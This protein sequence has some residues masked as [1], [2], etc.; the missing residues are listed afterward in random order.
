MGDHHGCDAQLLLQ[1]LDFVAQMH[2]HF[3]VKRRERFIKQQ[4]T[5]AG[6]DGAR[7]RNALL[8]ATRQLCRILLGLFGQT[9][10][11]QQ[12]YHTIGNLWFAAAGV[13]QSEGNI[14][15]DCQ[16]RKQSI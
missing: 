5:R 1:R 2:P 6:G 9:D 7:Q 13:F 14:L 15:L 3:G 10:K 4:Q 16:V 8:L 11:A 12:F